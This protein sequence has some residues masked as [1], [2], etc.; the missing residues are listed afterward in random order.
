[1][2]IWLYSYDELS[3]LNSEKNIEKLLEKSQENVQGNNN[4]NCKKIYEN[5]ENQNNFK[6]I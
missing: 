5:Q 2:Q 4:T 3:K 6:F 1:M